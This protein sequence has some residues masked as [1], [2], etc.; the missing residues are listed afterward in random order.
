MK[1]RVFSMVLI[2]V[3]LVC[4]IPVN[5]SAAQAQESVI[6]FDDGSYLR[7]TIE[8][9]S[10]RAT[11]TRTAN[12]YLTHYN[13]S[14]EVLWEAKLTASFTYTGTTSSCTSASCSVTVNDSAWYVVSKSASYSG[15]T[16]TAN[17][18]MGKKFLG[19]TIDKPKYTITLTCDK[20]GNLS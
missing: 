20:D 2:V 12:K 19:I 5:V 8:D 17:L 1:L 13:S 7:I 16:A 9:V 11:N 15:N 3:M 18:T 10:A 4:T 6:T 14:D